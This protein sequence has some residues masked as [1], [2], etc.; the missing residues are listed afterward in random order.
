[1]RGKD[2]VEARILAGE[3]EVQPV[4]VVRLVDPVGAVAARAVGRHPVGVHRHL[5]VV[6][7]PLSRKNGPPES[8]EQVPPRCGL[9][10]LF[11]NTIDDLS[12]TP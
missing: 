5:Q 6:V 9:P 2:S 12:W 7:V 3:D 4:D 10:L 1:M 11:E 8:P